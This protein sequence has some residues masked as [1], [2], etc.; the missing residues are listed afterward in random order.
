MTWRDRVAAR[1]TTIALLILF[2]VVAV[3]S[4]LAVRYLELDSFTLLPL[5]LKRAAPAPPWPDNI[6]KAVRCDGREGHL[7]YFF[8]DRF[9]GRSWSNIVPGGCRRPSRPPLRPSLVY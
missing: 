4:P 3:G 2:V 7:V 5:R 6:E 8:R 9:T 1:R